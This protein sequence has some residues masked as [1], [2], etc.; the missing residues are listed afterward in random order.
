MKGGE[1]GGGVKGIS[2]EGRDNDIPNPFIIQ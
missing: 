1:E 2:Y